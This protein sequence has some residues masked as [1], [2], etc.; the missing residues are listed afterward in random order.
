MVTCII[1]SIRFSW[2][3]GKKS[4]IKTAAIRGN[5][6]VNKETEKISCSIDPDSLFIEINSPV[7][8]EEIKKFLDDISEYT[9]RI[10]GFLTTDKGPVRIDGVREDVSINKVD[11]IK[12]P[13]GLVV[14][15]GNKNIL[16]EKLNKH[17]SEK[18][19]VV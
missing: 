13:E 19:N 16:K 2:F 3:V 9:L 1:L 6:K 5:T 15:T 14:F 12:K 8:Y 4:S 17:K 18:I 7:N 11:I 10:K